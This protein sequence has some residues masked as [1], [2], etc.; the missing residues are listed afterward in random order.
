MDSEKFKYTFALGSPWTYFLCC[1]VVVSFPVDKGTRR[2]HGLV[3][4][5]RDI[6]GMITDLSS[7]RR[8]NDDI[9]PCAL[10]TDSSGKTFVSLGSP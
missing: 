7:N 1:C 9:G 8:Q 4:L 10:S 3:G 6:A 2:L 5:W